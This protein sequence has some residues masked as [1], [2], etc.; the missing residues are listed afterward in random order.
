MRSSTPVIEETCTIT[1]KGQTTV[2]KSVRRALGVDYGGK[3]AFR[4]EGGRVTVR[5]PERE[6]ADPALRRFLDLLERDMATGKH[7]RQLPKGLAAA[8]RR[9]AKTGP[10]DLEPIDGD[11]EL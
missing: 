3:I 7:V 10:V 6:H 2:P 9:A 1:A 4:V 5:K 11:V 8:M